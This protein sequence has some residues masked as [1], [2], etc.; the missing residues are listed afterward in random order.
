MRDLFDLE[1]K[2]AVVT[3]STKGIGKAMAEGLAAAGATVVISSRK[4]DACQQVAAE[5]EARGERAVAIPCNVSHRD[6]LE[7]LVGETRRRCGAIDVLVCNAAVNPFHGSSL[8]I[9]DTAFEKI[10]KANVE[11]PHWLCQLVIPEMR[12][13][14]DGAIDFQCILV[15]AFPQVA[16]LVPLHIR[17]AVRDLNEPHS[18][19]REPP[20]EQTLAAKIL[21]HFV[22]HP[23]QPQRGRGLARNVLNLRHLGLHAERQLMN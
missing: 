11:S 16:M 7:H 12:E 19:F 9:P 4:E 5:F 1:G 23:V 14:R 2:V 17:V 20:R 22:V 6:Q 13:R 18:T 21:G 3:G 15:M 10:M 8:D